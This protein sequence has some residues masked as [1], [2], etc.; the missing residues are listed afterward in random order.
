MWDVR[1]HRGFIIDA[2]DTVDAYIVVHE[3]PF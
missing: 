1:D 2:A 3:C